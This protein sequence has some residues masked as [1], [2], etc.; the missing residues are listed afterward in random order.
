MDVRRFFP[1]QQNVAYLYDRAVESVGILY[2]HHYPNRAEDHR[3]TGHLFSRCTIASRRKVPASAWP[4]GWERADWFAPEGVEPVHSYSWGRPNWFEFQGVEHMAVREGV[5]LY[6]LSS[7]HK[8]IVQGPDAEAVLQN[9]CANDVAVPSGR[10]VYTAMLNERGG[11]ETDF[12]VTRIA[13]ETFF[14]V[15][16]VGTGVRDFDYIK[17]RIPLDAKASITDVTH[18]YAMLAVMGPDA[19]KLLSK[20]T[21]DDLSN[22]AFP[23]RTAKEIDLAYARPLA[24]RMSYVGEL[25]WEIYIPAGFATGVFD[26]IC[27]AGRQYGLR[28]VGMQAVNSLRMECGYRHWE[29]DITPDD[30]PFEAGLDFSVKLDKPDFVGREALLRAKRAAS[31]PQNG[32]LHPRRSRAH[33]LPKRTHIQRRE[34]GF[35]DHF[36]R[37][38]LQAGGLGGHGIS[39]ESRRGDAGLDPLG[40]IRNPGGRQNDS[41][42]GPHPASL[43][44]PW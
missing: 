36:R 4:R 7:M 6:D 37:L 23:F 31:S 42:Q 27:D 43:R 38:R 44:S 3:K 15:T 19:R 20:L 30:T 16:S 5:G 26:A 29:S 24:F 41:R 18:G 28:Q 32:S 8:Y 21:D 40:Q 17:R 2:E 9:L 1:W 35:P 22:E 10:I 14:I 39:E 33:A 13:E 25:G 34:A 11:F 12:T